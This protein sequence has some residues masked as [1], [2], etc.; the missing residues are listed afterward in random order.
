M[1]N[2]KEKFEKL[3]EK[4]CELCNKNEHKQYKKVK[5]SERKNEKIN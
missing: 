4:A 2:N 3:I 5:K 1:R